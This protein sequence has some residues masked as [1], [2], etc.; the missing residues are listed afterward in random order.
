MSTS[1]A[2]PNGIQS[3]GRREVHRRTIDCRAHLRDD[4]LLD[5]EATLLDV[6]A[7]DVQ[8]IA[9]LLP[10]GEPLHRMT[11]RLAVDGDFVVREVE[12]H[13]LDA[14]FAICGSITPRYELMIGMTIGVGF[15][16]ECRRLLRGTHGCTHLTELLPVIAT[17]AF[18]ARSAMHK[19]SEDAAPGSPRTRA[20]AFGKCHALRLD[21]EV[22]RRHHPELAIGPGASN[23][24]ETSRPEDAGTS[25]A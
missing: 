7:D 1:D 10:A 25:G 5:V 18:Q 24:G 23:T 21:G 22:V 9:K 13:T 2:E 6:K 16:Q 14:P 12:A 11:V 3:I 19:N 4:G 15:L 8:L 17:T 20:S